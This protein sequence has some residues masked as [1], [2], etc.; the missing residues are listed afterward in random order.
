MRANADLL[1]CCC[2]LPNCSGQ[3]WEQGQDIE[4]KGA[5]IAQKWP[6][7]RLE[8]KGWGLGMYEVWIVEVE[9][10]SGMWS[11]IGHSYWTALASADVELQELQRREA[12]TK[13]GSHEYRIARYIRQD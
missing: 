7:E 2:I 3:R 13:V 8:G 12:V 6:Q 10:R 5:H 4:A 1:T 11:P 9:G